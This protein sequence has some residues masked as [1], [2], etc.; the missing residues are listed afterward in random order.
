METRGRMTAPR[1]L[2]RG[3]DTMRARE[4]ATAAPDPV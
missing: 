3:G 2:A 4:G 1:T